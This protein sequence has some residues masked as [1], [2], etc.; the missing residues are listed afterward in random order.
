[1]ANCGECGVYGSEDWIELMHRCQPRDREKYQIAVAYGRG[2]EDAAKL[3]DRIEL[4]EIAVAI[5]ALK[6]EAVKDLE[7]KK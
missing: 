3:C 5:R 6:G 7:V 4:P 1:M 2:L